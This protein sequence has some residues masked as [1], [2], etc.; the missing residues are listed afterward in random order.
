MTL[1][2]WFD[3]LDDRKAGWV[4]VLTLNQEEYLL[5]LSAPV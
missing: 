4:D 3:G 2:K 1:S 5:T